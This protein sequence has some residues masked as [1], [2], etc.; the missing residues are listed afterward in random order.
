[1]KRRTAI[2]TLGGLAGAAVASRF[3]SGCKGDD[4]SDDGPLKG[5]TTVVAL[6]MEN[7]SF[8][9]YLGARKLMGVDSS[10]GLVAG[11]SN[12]DMDG[13]P[14]EIQTAMDMCMED[15]PHD[16]DSCHNAF[17]GGAND[18]F[19]K[20]MQ[21]AHNG[22]AGIEPMTYMLR[23][24]IPVTWAL[25]DSGAV[26]DA[27]YSSVMGPT[28]PNR[29]YWLSG[30]SSGVKANEV[31]EQGFIWDSIFHRLD[32]K[33]VPWAFYFTDIGSLAIAEN[34][35]F[36]NR[37]RRVLPDFLKEAAAGT[38]PP[39]CYIDP[40]FSSNDDHPPHHPL[41]G[42]QFIS[43][44]YN[45]L[46]N[47]PQW[48]NILFVITYDEHGGFFDHVAPPTT[49][50]MFAS[51]GF[52]QLGFRVPSLVLGPYVKGGSVISTPF[53]HTSMLKHIEDMFELDPLTERTSA[54][55][56]LES[57]IDFERLEAGKP[58]EPI[59]LPAVEIDES[60]LP[61]RCFYNGDEARMGDVEKLAAKWSAA[62]RFPKELDLRHEARDVPFKV[63]EALDA[64]GA[65]RIRL[66]K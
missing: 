31:P 40:G 20:A 8:D 46:A 25:A 18:G 2:K 12:P 6:M 52:D 60:S 55:N 56:N 5:I 9:H 33:E 10:N 65:G 23:E 50:D 27:W 58:A 16:W 42:Q 61:D 48:E 29:M 22:S 63:G 32:E 13:T 41:L 4:V 15:P 51:E 3:L 62:G 38:L 64:M 59:E 26:C 37:V 53:D 39:V 11:M 43:M 57:C 19:V 17:N 7:R 21:A 14:I 34:L 30:Q 36:G 54:A 24:H 1:M 45:A 66:G 28:W 47:S 49:S 44:I 35:D